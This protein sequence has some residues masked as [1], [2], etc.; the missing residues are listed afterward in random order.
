MQEDWNKIDVK[1]LTDNPFHLF[2]D[3][4]MLITAGTRDKFNMMT[5]SWGMFG[6][7]WNKPVAVCFI[8][9]Q[10]YTRRFADEN[11]LFTLCF[12]PGN[13]RG[14]LEFCGSKSGR[15]VDKVKETGLTPVFTENGT[16]IYKEARLAFEC[17]KLYYDDFH[18]A[19]FDK[20]SLINQIYSS[21]DFH[22]F[23]I[24]EILACFVRI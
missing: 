12:F 23:Y 7:L 3:E 19:Q 15:Y 21:G 9:P 10:R 18:A 16:I 24:G 1:S 13:Y 22:R 20:P 4:W 17:R 14:V 8:R 2:D 6:I 5:A 11:S